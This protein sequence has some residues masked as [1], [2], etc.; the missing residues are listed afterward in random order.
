MFIRIN[1]IEVEA[2]RF[3]S[4]DRLGFETFVTGRGG[5]VSPAPF[6][7]LNI[8]DKEGDDKSNVDENMRRIKEALGLSATWAPRQTHGDSIVVI[9]GGA[10][11]EMVEADAVVSASPAISI[12]V[13]TADCL[14]V[15]LADPVLKSIA[16]IHAGRKGTEMG[17]ASKVVELM[18]ARLYV[19]PE[20]LHAALKALTA[21]ANLN[22]ILSFSNI[23][24]AI[25]CA[26]LPGEKV[27]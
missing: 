1:N 5:G 8:G 20:N 3:P 4:L 7:T 14:P 24:V 9:G 13:R 16:V 11:N 18:Q 17:I 15:I 26:Q 21:V 19:N 22:R 10:P 27:F 25:K 23:H 12:F 2:Y 6:D